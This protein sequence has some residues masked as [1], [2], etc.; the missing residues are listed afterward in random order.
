MDSE[1]QMKRNMD[2]VRLV[3]LAV[4]E[5]PEAELDLAPEIEGYEETDIVNH[6]LLLTRAG[7]LSSV[8]IGDK[9]DVAVAFIKLEWAGHDLL[10]SIRNPETWKKTKEHASKVGGWTAKILADIAKGLIKQQL[11]ERGIHMG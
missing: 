7:Y 8:H 9:D 2:L 1:R 3:L 4:E 6:I 10:D 11:I 5:A